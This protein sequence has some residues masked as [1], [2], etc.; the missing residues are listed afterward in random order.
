MKNNNAKLWEEYIEYAVLVFAIL[1]LAWYAWGAFGTNIEEKM[2]N[3][4]VTTSTVDAELEK[5]ADEIASQQNESSSPIDIVSPPSLGAEFDK[6]ASESVSPEERV[7]FPTLDMTA[8]LNEDQDVLAELVMFATPVIPAPESVRTRQWF[9]TILD[10]E[11]DRVE[12]L[13]DSIEGSPYDTSWVQIDAI[14]DI[15]ASV[16]SFK[17]SSEGLQSIPDRWYDGGADIFDVQIERQRLQDGIWSDSETISVL[18]GHLQYRDRVEDGSIDSSEKEKIIHDLR[19]GLQAEITSPSFY[20]CK[21][22]QPSTEDLDPINWDES[23]K[24]NTDTDKD[25][26]KL[27][28]QEKKITKQQKLIDSIQKKIDDEGRGVSGGGSPRIGGG[29]S[30]GNSKLDRLKKQLLS[31]K[32]KLQEL[33]DK[34][35]EL[36]DEIASSLEEQPNVEVI[37][38]GKLRVWG[39]DMT[40]IAGETYR[41]RMSVDLANPFYGHK[42]SLFP[43]QKSLAQKVTMSS[44]K[45]DW[46]SNIEVQNPIQWFIVN[47]RNSGESMNPDVLDCGF[48]TVEYFEFSDGLWEQN[49]FAVQVG[50]RIGQL[51]QE[52]TP[53]DWFVLDILE[54]TVGDVVILQHI[55]S[56]QL[57]MVYPQS[58]SNRTELHLLRQQVREQ[59]V[60]ESEEE[61]TPT[62]PV[63]PQT[64]GQ[65]GPIGTTGGGGSMR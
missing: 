9:G 27:E 11:I 19:D 42:P 43:E 53:V 55:H 58:E 36:E 21:N 49:T 62:E 60:E 20:L 64:G 50:Q 12:G 45:S 35:Q 24:E 13:G 14:F 63:E 32:Q 38:S 51:D 8:K 61:V 65:G 16:E 29:G 48:V 52:G 23:A 1:V 3:H 2:G 34:K 6:R 25:K 59:Q 46:S 33:Q 15:D 7:F 17:V 10:S 18:P 41:Y 28:L 4:V 54:N 22:D 56:P 57:K 31:A 40:A 37:L 30:G 39:H 44:Q 5:V 47:A 26:K